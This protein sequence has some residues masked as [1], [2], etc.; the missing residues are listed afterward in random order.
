MLPPPE[1]TSL[2]KKIERLPA[3][4]FAERWHCWVFV[5]CALLLALF[6]MLPKFGLFDRAALYV[7]IPWKRPCY[8]YFANHTLQDKEAIDVLFLG[9][10]SLE[11]A[12]DPRVLKEALRPLLGRE[13][14]VVVAGHA[15]ES[16]A[17]DYIMLHDLLARRKVRM[18]AL[19][20][21]RESKYRYFS[22]GD[23]SR[24]FW[25]FWLHWDVVR[26]LPPEKMLWT[27]LYT[28]RYALRL[29]TAP[30]RQR[31]DAVHG[32]VCQNPDVTFGACL[33]FFPD[34]KPKVPPPAPKV[35]TSDL[36]FTSANG[37]AI[38][39]DEYIPDDLLFQEA[40]LA[41]AQRHGTVVTFVQVPY[42]IGL[43]TPDGVALPRA[44]ATSR[45]WHTPLIA[46][47]VPQLFPGKSRRQIV[48]EFYFEP[49]G[50]HF[51]A[52][53]ASY[54]TKVIAPAVVKLFQE[55]VTP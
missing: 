54:F 21:G 27:Y 15:G 16:L 53:G 11:S 20:R 32:Y 23:Y 8:V 18:L 45:S 48:E 6:P 40:T 51:F 31:L 50:K 14:V 52:V 22:S 49:T 30:L 28:M 36:L 25:D 26:Q 47:S 46:A 42:D 43:E 10:S 24:G 7:D 5:L 37:R 39:G 41:L 13:P 19:H 2:E 3:P 1:Q 34:A 9:N 4:A 44:P 55:Q 33:R 12:I 38:A 17:L 35:P 29:L